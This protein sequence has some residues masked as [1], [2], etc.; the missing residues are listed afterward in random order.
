[1]GFNAV[2]LLFDNYRTIKLPSVPMD[3]FISE[4][5]VYAKLVGLKPSTVIQS[6]GAGGGGTWARWERREGSPTLR[7]ADRIRAWMIANPPKSNEDAA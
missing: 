6:A 1:M 7:T 2:D 4:V 5:R 3:E